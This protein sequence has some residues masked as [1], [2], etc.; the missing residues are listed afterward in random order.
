MTRKAESKLFCCCEEFEKKDNLGSADNKTGT[1]HKKSQSTYSS[2]KCDKE[3]LVLALAETAE[4]KNVL[5]YVARSKEDVISSESFYLPLFREGEPESVLGPEEN[6]GIYLTIAGIGNKANVET[7]MTALKV[8]LQEEI[9]LWGFYPT[10]IQVSLANLGSILNQVAR[11]S[12]SINYDAELAIASYFLNSGDLTF[13][14]LKSDGHFHQVESPFVVLG[15]R[16]KIPDQN[17]S[18]RHILRRELIQ[19]YKKFKWQ[20]RLPKAREVYRLSRKFLKLIE[21]GISWPE[22]KKEILW[23][24]E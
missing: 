15:G 22:I 4:N 11:S 9:S 7:L 8:S 19:L 16:K 18:A 24:F 14:R 13:Y 17:E 23:S 3:I 5:F 2:S 10:I 21:P 1:P 12:N 20:N 6:G